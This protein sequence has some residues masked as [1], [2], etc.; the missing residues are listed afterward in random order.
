MC[1]GHTDKYLSKQ[2][3]KP[4]AYPLASPHEDN[5]SSSPEEEKLS[6]VLLELPVSVVQ[7]AYL[8]SLQP[9][10]DAMEVECVLRS[11][12]WVRYLQKTHI[13]E[14]SKLTLQIPQATVHSSVVDEPWFA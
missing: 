1:G 7:W 11:E 6:T 9:S 13:Q 2:R 3:L 8:T 12:T 10:R 5:V 4:V 14:K